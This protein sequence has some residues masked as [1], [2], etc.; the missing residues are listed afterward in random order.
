MPYPSAKK[1]GRWHPSPVHK[2]YWL[3]IVDLWHPE[4]HPESHL[5]SFRVAQKVIL[6]TPKVTWGHWQHN[7]WFLGG[8]S[9]VTRRVILVSSRRVALAYTRATKVIPTM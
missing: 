8:L 4:G 6:R 3:L 2:S 5:E 1:M 9:A 7:L